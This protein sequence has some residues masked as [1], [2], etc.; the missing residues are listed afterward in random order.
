[1]KHCRIALIALL[2]SLSLVL[3]LG[4]PANAERLERSPQVVAVDATTGSTEIWLSGI[5]PSA[6]GVSVSAVEG[7]NPVDVQ[8]I[9]GT[10]NADTPVE[11]VYVVDRAA[12]GVGTRTFEQVRAHIESIAGSVAAGGPMKVGVVGAGDRAAVLSTLTDDVAQLQRAVAQLQ[13]QTDASLGEALAKAA[14]QFSSD[15]GVVRSI[16]MV[17]AGPASDQALPSG[18]RSALNR[19]GVQ[20]YSVALD[21][22]SVYSALASQ[23]GGASYVLGSGSVGPVLQSAHGEAVV[24]TVATVAETGEVGERRS[25]TLTVNDTEL[26]VTYGVGDFTGVITRLAFAPPEVATTGDAIFSSPL[27]LIVIL[28]LA[29][30]GIGL[31]I[32]AVASIVFARTTSLEGLL[33][34]YAD[35]HADRPEEEDLRE[36]LI[37]T[38]LM[39][40]AVAFGE[41]L[42]EHRGLL[43]KTELML[44]RANIPIRAGEG[45]VLTAI[46]ALL[47]GMFLAFV[48]NSALFGLLAIVLTPMVAVTVVRIKARR[49]MAAFEGQLP[50][51]LH[52]LSGTLRAG[53][54]LN[55]GFSA[56][57]EEMASPIGPELQ[58]A[59]SEARLGRDL[60]ECL[61]GVADRLD[62]ADFRWVV[63]ALGIQRD[64]GGN[65]NELLRSVAT[66]MVERDRLKREVKVLTAEG[67][68]SAGVLVFLPPGLGLVMWIMNRDYLTVLFQSTLGNVLLAA[69]VAST[70]A[71]VA[72]MKKVI[73][74]DV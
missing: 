1:M 58:R 30:I 52:L 23:S 11:I 20:F 27:A 26:G 43:G 37:E 17:S 41:T 74:I 33:A 31:G 56:V 63:L 25:L 60:E 66:T 68:M 4:A 55:Q 50:D 69:G 35:P 67:K 70:L 48:T 59:M 44:E 28:V 61:E 45:L 40:R 8:S 16:V 38:A 64:V 47:G 21:G 9:A 29:A 32:W 57:A 5:D 49:R 18:I 34:Q 72:W 71:G 24:R 39:K 36:A 10:T 19:Q 73:T 42:A 3:G 46:A 22:N 62:S 12:R 54:S 7:S 51:A 13:I 2:L 14:N 15:P 65:L 6:G 53:F